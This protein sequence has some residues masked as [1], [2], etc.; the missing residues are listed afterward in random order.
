VP[1]NNE[2]FDFREIVFVVFR[3]KFLIILSVLTLSLLSATY[4]FLTPPIY[5]G[6]ALIEIGDLFINGEGTNSKPA[7]IQTI[8]K[9]NDL[10]EVLSQ[11]F[12]SDASDESTFQLESPRGSSNLLRM[13]YLNSNKDVIAKKLNDVVK[14]ALDHLDKTS[15]FF[16]NS[17]AQIRPSV[18]IGEIQISSEPVK[19]SKLKIIL[20]GFFGGLL[21]G[22][23]ISFLLQSL[24]REKAH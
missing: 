17:N 19:P 4:A 13:T 15:L 5:Q 24:R 2:E 11:L 22:L 8:Q 23:A 18:L 20:S 1:E 21:L 3:Y 7:L 16:K 9:A 10:H 12:Y 6:Q 14:A